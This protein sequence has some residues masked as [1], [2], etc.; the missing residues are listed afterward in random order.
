MSAWNNFHVAIVSSIALCASRSS[1]QNTS[2]KYHKF[3]DFSSEHKIL[4]KK[5]VSIY[6]FFE[7]SIS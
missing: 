6:G 3:K 1:I 7:V 2:H 5:K 4:A